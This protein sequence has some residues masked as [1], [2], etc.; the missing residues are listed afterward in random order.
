MRRAAASTHHSSHSAAM[1]RNQ[2]N[3][4]SYT[5]VAVSAESLPAANRRCEAATCGR[6]ATLL[7]RTLQQTTLQAIY[8]SKLSL[9][10]RPALY[11]KLQ[12]S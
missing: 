2:N 8:S 11:A 9:T 7:T 3:Q 5:A 10:L 12:W 1:Q 4:A 6:S